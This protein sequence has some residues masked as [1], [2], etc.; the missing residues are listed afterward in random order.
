VV[1]QHARQVGFCWWYSWKAQER[2]SH[3]LGSDGVCARRED[4]TMGSRLESW[5][6]A[7][8]TGSDHGVFHLLP[9]LDRQIPFA[10]RLTGDLGVCERHIESTQTFSTISFRI[11]LQLPNWIAGLGSPA[12]KPNFETL[13]P[14]LAI[15][16]FTSYRHRRRQRERLVA[17]REEKARESRS[18]RPVIHWRGKG[19]R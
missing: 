12:L 1:Y 7:T 5:L 16:G 2:G 18:R 6:A 13:G 8:E 3:Q 11:Q 4:Q 19:G 17:R 15:S 10:K 9:Q 14:T